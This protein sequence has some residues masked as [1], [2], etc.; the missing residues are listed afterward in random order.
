MLIAP[1]VLALAIVAIALV[2]GAVRW[3]IRDKRQG[4]AGSAS[5]LSRVQEEVDAHGGK[6]EYSDTDSYEALRHHDRLG[7]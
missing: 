1:V 3:Y 6:R 2:I 7:R 4:S 5:Y